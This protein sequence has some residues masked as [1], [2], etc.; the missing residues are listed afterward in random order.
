MN[1]R[2]KLEKAVWNLVENIRDVVTRDVVAAATSQTVK[3]DKK[4]FEKLMMVVQ[5][6]IEKGYHNG[7]REYAKVVA[8]CEKE[9]LDGAT[10]PTAKK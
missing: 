2:S 10:K 8:S 9:I 3:I 6:G 5:S 4:E 7:L 1:A